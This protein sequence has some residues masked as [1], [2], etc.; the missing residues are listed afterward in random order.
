MSTSFPAST[1]VTTP[2]ILSSS[3]TTSTSIITS[4]STETTLIGVGFLDFEID[5]VRLGG[6]VLLGVI[7]AL[8]GIDGDNVDVLDILPLVI[9]DVDDVG[10]LDV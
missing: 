1:T 8:G 10:V 3:E 7:D 4:P 6:F 9:L 5:L 2:T